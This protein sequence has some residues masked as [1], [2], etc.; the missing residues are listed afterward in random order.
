LDESGVLYV[1]KKNIS[2][3]INIRGLAVSATLANNEL[4]GGETNSPDQE[5][6][7]S[8]LVHCRREP[9]EAMGIIAKWIASK[10]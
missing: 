6:P 5:V 3:N 2:L 10:T 9:I 1:N 7:D 8:L 4:A